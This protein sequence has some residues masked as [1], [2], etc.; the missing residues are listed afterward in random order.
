[1]E[2]MKRGWFFA[3]AREKLVHSYLV[4]GASGG[5]IASRALRLYI[6]QKMRL[7]L[8]SWQTI[9]SRPRVG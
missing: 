4:D 2:T 3:G 8:H 1:M 6:S 9:C 5:A 7:P